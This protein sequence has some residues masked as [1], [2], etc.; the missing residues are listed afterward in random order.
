VNEESGPGDGEGGE[1]KPVERPTRG[2]NTR[3]MRRDTKRAGPQFAPDSP[4]AGA[5]KFLVFFGKALRLT[6][7]YPIEH[8]VLQ[9]GLA[10]GHRAYEA[11]VQKLPRVTLG[12][13][14]GDLLLGNA[15]IRDV[16]MGIAE[17]YK[18][19]ADLGIES[20]IIDSGASAEHLLGFLR[21]LASQDPSLDDSLPYKEYSEPWFTG[22][23]VLRGGC[24][25]TRARLIRNPWRNFY[26]PHRRDVWAG[27]RT[28]ALRGV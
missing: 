10:E 22:H 25:T 3:R 23:K 17:L 6:R 1:A 11:M 12:A 5:I 27:F 2:I 7:L 4:E 18:L 9:H 20:L 21:L 28:C 19:F 15:P 8:P 26:Q 24:W 14:G 13:R 16:T